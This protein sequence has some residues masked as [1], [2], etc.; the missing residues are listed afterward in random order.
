MPAEQ[1][2]C[3]LVGVQQVATLQG[4]AEMPRGALGRHQLTGP[5][6]PPVGGAHER[7]TTP[8]PASGVEHRASP[9]QRTP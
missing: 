7:R 1:P 9:Y 6:Q 3:L 8:H 4:D 2:F 5:V